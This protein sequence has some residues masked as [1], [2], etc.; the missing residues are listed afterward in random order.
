[1]PTAPLETARHLEW[2]TPWSLGVLIVCVAAAAVWAIWQSRREA[3]ATDSRWPLMFL[4]PRLIIAGVLVW[5]MLGPTSVL[6]R[7][8]MRPC[9]LGVYVDASSSMRLQDQPDA[10]TDRRWSLAAEDAPVDPIVLADTAALFAEALYQETSRF[11]ELIDQ[12]AGETERRQSLERWSQISNKC[13]ERLVSMSSSFSGAD[14]ST[15]QQLT[16]LLQTELQ[17]LVDGPGGISA[18]DLAEQEDKLRVWEDLSRQ[19]ANS[20]QELADRVSQTSGGVN[21]PAENSPGTIETR[22][23]KVVPALEHSL[24]AWRRE[25]SNSFRILLSEFAETV[26]PLTASDQLAALSDL[27][28]ASSTDSAPV[29]ETDLTELLRQIRSESSEDQLSAAVLLTDGRQTVPG[30]DDPRRLAAQLRVPLYIV[31]IGWG[32]MRRDVILHHLHAPSSVI[33]KDTILIE[34]IVT[35]FGCKGEVCEVQLVEGNQVR[36]SKTLAFRHDQEDQHVRFDVETSEVGRREFT[37]RLSD[38]R[39]EFTR[40]NNASTIGVDVV[41]AVLRVLIAEDTARWEH[42]FLVNLLRRQQQMEFDQLRFSPQTVGTGSRQATGLFPETVAEWSEYRVVIL[43]DVSPRQLSRSSQEGLR[44]FVTKRG[45]SLIVIAGK[46]AMPHAFDG[47][48]LVDLLPVEQSRDAGWADAGYR[49]ELT[50]EGKTLDVMRLGEDV[51]S[52]EAIWRQM[53]RSLPIDFPNRYCQPKPTS[54]V[55]LAAL[56]GEAARTDQS[57]AY[58]CWQQVGAGRVAYLSSP[59]TYQLRMRSGDKY[60]YRFWGQFVRWIASNS[61]TKGSKTVRLQTDKSNYRMGDAVEIR[62]ELS[63]ESGRPLAGAQPVIDA[64]RSEQRD[65]VIALNSDPKVPGRYLG[66]FAA[67]ESG[68]YT[69]RAA[70][71]EVDQLLAREKVTDGVEIQ[72]EYEPELDR[73]QMDPRADRP[74][75]EYLARRT[76]GAVLEPTTLAN[77]HQVLALEPRTLESAQ[78]TPL[79]DRWWCLG[80]I[81][82]CLTVEWLLRKRAGLA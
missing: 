59:T 32:E 34:A 37:I 64:L 1:M 33:Q 24:A 28:E 15:A 68:R 11:I 7:K 75:L 18:D 35:A 66:K 38:T 22:L 61:L 65:A 43:G 77:L 46:N 19:L 27:A 10:V 26:S 29:R 49:V 8:E 56:P 41:D 69:L 3:H 63:D 21:A 4:L 80:I 17:P 47:E 30:E 13:A 39:D 14:R 51:P 40:E 42:Q 20:C 36:N 48:P 76:G 2:D 44:E 52:T 70:G 58:L 25:G 71:S 23:K 31:P 9:S 81:A 55:L 82:G 62:L 50:A 60:H 74:L 16:S 5:M 57:R 12:Q 72:I 73:E 53:S 67:T 45:G 79:W 6:V 54:T 78:R